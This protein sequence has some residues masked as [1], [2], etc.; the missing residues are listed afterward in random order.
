MVVNAAQY[1]IDVIN[2][3]YMAEDLLPLFIK[4]SQ[5]DAKPKLKIKLFEIFCDLVEKSD[6]YFDSINVVRS[7]LTKIFSMIDP[8]SK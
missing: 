1:Y 7:Y 5:V 4:Y 3:L 8:N 6:N 2:D